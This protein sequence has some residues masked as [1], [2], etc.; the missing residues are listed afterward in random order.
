MAPVAAISNSLPDT[1]GQILDSIELQFKLD[2]VALTRI[3]TQFLQEVANG[4]SEYGQAMAIMYVQQCHTTHLPQAFTTRRQPSPTF[5]T[6][7]PSGKEKG[8]VMRLSTK[9]YPEAH[10]LIIAVD[11]QHLPRS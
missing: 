11:L 2:D 10:H 1:V 6:G 9:P 4:L 5:V 7:V 3:T 8:S